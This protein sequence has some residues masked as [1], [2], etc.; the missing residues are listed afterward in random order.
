MDHTAPRMGRQEQSARSLFDQK[1]GWK[2]GYFGWV[3][4]KGRHQRYWPSVT[5]VLPAYNRHSSDPDQDVTPLEMVVTFKCHSR[6]IQ[7][8]DMGDAFQEAALVLWR[9]CLNAAVVRRDL[10]IKEGFKNYYRSLKWRFKI[11]DPVDRDRYRSMRSPRWRPTT[12]VE[13]DFRFHDEDERLSWDP[14]SSG[15]SDRSARGRKLY[16][17]KQFIDYTIDDAQLDFPLLFYAAEYGVTAVEKARE[18]GVSPTAIKKKRKRIGVF[19]PWL[20]R[21]L[22]LP[23][24]RRSSST[25]NGITM[26]LSRPSSSPRSTNLLAPYWKRSQAN[27]ESARAWLLARKKSANKGYARVGSMPIYMVEGA[28]CTLPVDDISFVPIG[29]V[30]INR[31]EVRNEWNPVGSGCSL[32]TAS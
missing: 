12:F 23:E 10:S 30:T 29:T 8:A 1:A 21:W 31:T 26:K 6:R 17:S 16:R 9:D 28:T 20:N 27:A 2:T 25:C 4:K 7:H 11:K 19:V 32:A 18:M 14:S 24:D 15:R 3:W 22:Y 13:S 5:P